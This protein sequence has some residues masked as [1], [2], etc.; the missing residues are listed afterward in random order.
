MSDF[1]IHDIPDEEKEAMFKLGLKEIS[2]T[3]SVAI[4]GSVISYYQTLLARALP[5]ISEQSLRVE[6]EGALS[7]KY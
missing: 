1:I 6:I 3:R 2:Y 4:D 7:V 5:F